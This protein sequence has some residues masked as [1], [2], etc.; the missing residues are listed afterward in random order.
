MWFRNLRLFRLERDWSPSL[1]DFE[2]SLRH[3]AFSGCG[4]LDMQSQGWVPPRG[5]DGE[6]VVAVNHHWLIALGVEQKLL[7]SSVIRQYVQTQLQELEAKQGFK[8]G[9]GQIREV[10]EAVTANLLPKAF[11][12]RR[13]TYVWIDVK[14]RWLGIDAASP[15]KADE[16]IE[17][18]KHTLE[19]FP[20]LP[21]RTAVAPATAMTSWLVAG[22]AP[23][24]FDI[25]RDCE[26]RA[27][28][29]DKATIRYSRH[30]L[31]GEEIRHHIEAGKRA[32]KLALSW[33]DRISF[34]LGED[35][36]LKR[37]A[38]LDMLQEESERHAEQ[39]DDLFESD[40]AIAT[41]ELPQLAAEVISALGG[42]ADT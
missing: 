2:E 35:F 42:E 4:A 19:S 21:I 8:P 23:G 22:E 34:V 9:R 13:L 11:V 29:Q 14:N 7:P 10:K 33:N 31:D 20:L 36:S 27:P 18:L 17:Q 12:R 40:F 30:A 26:L 15:A 28:S 3:Q 16:V 24:R 37:L 1:A 39:G 25:D 38:F 5:N 6:L 41:G 32:T